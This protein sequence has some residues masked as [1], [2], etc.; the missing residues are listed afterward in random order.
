MQGAA[1]QRLLASKGI[2]PHRTVVVYDVQ[3]LRSAAM[4]HRLRTSGYAK[5]LTYDAGIAAWVDQLVRGQSPA[6]YYELPTAVI[7]LSS[8]RR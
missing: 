4:A 3:R 2:T 6:T 8:L 5:I 1:L 7:S